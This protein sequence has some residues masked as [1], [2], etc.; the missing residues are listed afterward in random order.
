[1]PPTLGNGKICYVEIPATD[2][3]EAISCQP[4]VRN[5]EGN[6]HLSASC[7]SKLRADGGEL[8]GTPPVLSPD[9]E[10]VWAKPPDSSTRTYRKRRRNGVPLTIV[11]TL[12]CL[13]VVARNI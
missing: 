11:V 4:S 2:I 10:K 5:K 6:A 12:P 1:M 7:G 9:F 8:K 13:A 3:E